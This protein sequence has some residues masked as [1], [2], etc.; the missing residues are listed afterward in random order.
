MDSKYVEKFREVFETACRMA[1]INPSEERLKYHLNLV[2]AE[3]NYII[4]T[5][6]LIDD[7][8]YQTAEDDWWE[9]VMADMEILTREY[10][11]IYDKQK[12]IIAYGIA[13]PP[14]VMQDAEL[15]DRYDR[16]MSEGTQ[17]VKITRGENCTP[18]EICCM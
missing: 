15:R 16:L 8:A 3:M 5:E 1:G 2:R 17:R 10:G 18:E 12:D 13:Y 14:A 6:E 9:M 4:V 7:A 11:I